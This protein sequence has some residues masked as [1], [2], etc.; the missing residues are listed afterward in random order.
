MEVIKAK[1]LYFQPRIDNLSIELHKCVDKLDEITKEID[2]YLDGE[3]IDIFQL[4][5]M[6]D[7][8]QMLAETKKAVEDQIQRITL[9]TLN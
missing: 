9:E 4:N 6:M 1:D 7:H 8:K 2:I 5:V 3:M